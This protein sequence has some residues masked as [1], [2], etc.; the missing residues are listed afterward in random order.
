MDSNNKFP[1]F[2]PGKS[3]PANE[4]IKIISADLREKV[5]TMG[6]YI[7]E[8]QK[9]VLQTEKE[10]PTQEFSKFSEIVDQFIS[11]NK[12]GSIDRLSVGFP[13][14]VINNQAESSR[15]PWSLDVEV[16]KNE[17]QIS[18]VFLINDLEASAYG[19]ANIS[20]ECLIP[21]NKIETPS[22]GNLAILSPGNGLGEAGLFF[23]G[24]CLRPFAT[25]G[26]HSE[27]S[28][29]TTVEVEFYQFLNKIY[30]I[31]SWE[32][33]LSKNGLFNI[34]RFLRDEKRHPMSEKFIAKMQSDEEFSNVLYSSAVEDNEQICTIAINTFLEFLAREANS[35]VLKL[36]ATGGLLIGGELP[37]LFKDYID[38]KRFYD[39]FMISDKMDRL[40][41]GIP[42]YLLVNEKMIMNG[43]AT[44]AGFSQE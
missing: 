3:N 43:A 7:T 38:N 31:V 12:F 10:F 19:L 27:F 28:P 21:V 15:L 30:G 11:E 23:D 16:L 1:L 2:L 8:N 5:C 18:E 36:K 44:Y 25:E 9:A 22:T 6:F 32:S 37:I 42:I 39:K 17:T 20:E 40:L 26:G 24:K 35:L 4:G 33:V 29:R 14:P 41:K 13:G 34:F